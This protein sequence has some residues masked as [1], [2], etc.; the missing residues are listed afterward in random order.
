MIWK[1][2]TISNTIFLKIYIDIK[3]KL[4]YNINV[5]AIRL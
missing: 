2:V 3:I 5:T 1:S 4:T